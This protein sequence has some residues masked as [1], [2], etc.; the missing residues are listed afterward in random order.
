MRS[1]EASA[2]GAPTLSIVDRSVSISESRRRAPACG[3]SVVP[4]DMPQYGSYGDRGRKI[5]TTRRSTLIGVAALIWNVKVSPA[6]SPSDSASPALTAT[7]L[8]AL[9]QAPTTTTWAQ[10]SS[11]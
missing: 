10:T 9:G 3:E 6:L 4:V 8:V 7:S 11:R 1:T 2:D 5:P